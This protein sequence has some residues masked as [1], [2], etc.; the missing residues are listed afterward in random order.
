[1]PQETNVSRGNLVLILP[2]F[3]GHPEQ[4]LEWSQSGGCKGCQTEISKR[5]DSWGFSWVDEGC[6]VM[7]IRVCLPWT[8]L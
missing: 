2:L 1:M 6:H 7:V 3:E 5:P 8:C 4:L